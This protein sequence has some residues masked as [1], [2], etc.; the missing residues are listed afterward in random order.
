MQ[1]MIKK[2]RKCPDLNPLYSHATSSKFL[3]CKNHCQHQAT[4]V[5]MGGKKKEKYN[6]VNI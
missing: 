1:K 6:F 3:K 2:Y 4:V 5:L